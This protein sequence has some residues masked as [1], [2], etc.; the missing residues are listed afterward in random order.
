[1]IPILYKAD[2]TN[3]NTYGIGAL[4]EATSCV[5]KEERN[6]GYEL[7]LKYPING[8]LYSEIKKERIIKAKPNDTS[9]NQTFRIYRITVPIN[10]VITVYA[11]HISYDLASIAVTPFSLANV[12]PTQAVDKVLSSTV[13]PH[14]FK[15]RTDYSSTKDFII[16]KPKS[17]RA[18]LGGTEGSLL[19]QWGGEFEWDN[20]NIIHHQ[21][22]GNNNGV[23][24]EYGKNLTKL[25]QDS[26]VSDVYTDLLPYAVSKDAE[27]N[28]KVV[29]L[30]EQLIPISTTLEKRKSLIKDFTD[31][32]KD[33]EIVDEDKLRSKAK[34]YLENNP[35]GIENPTINISFEE[36]WKQ[37]DYIAILERVSLCD[38]VDRKSVV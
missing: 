14:S 29:T 8:L 38:T 35:L 17:V 31:S 11:E 37:P 23:V 32:F 5:V 16:D 4:A 21:K 13:L 24:I 18:C 3:F 28:E 6:G 15:F 10:G 33:E 12:T 25:E 34:E 1:M 26:D 7:T 20:F 2:T 27:G 36:L 9:D 30:T 19:N 22:R